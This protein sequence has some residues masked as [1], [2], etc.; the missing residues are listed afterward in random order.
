MSPNMD[1]FLYGLMMISFA[2]ALWMGWDWPTDARIFPV[3]VGSAG[4]ILA[5]CGSFLQ[6]AKNTSKGLDRA[7]TDSTIKNELRA[8]GWIGFFFLAVA[9]FGF[10]WGL[11][12][13][14]FVYL[15]L[16]ARL[17]FLSDFIFTSACWIFLYA[18]RVTLHL[19]LY[20]GYAFMHIPFQ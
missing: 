8:F 18:M 3:L 19:P 14:V 20:D 10:Q 12:A 4:L 11:P 6:F 2:G 1:R 5:I 9:L 16:E 17:K 13:A 15:T 7:S